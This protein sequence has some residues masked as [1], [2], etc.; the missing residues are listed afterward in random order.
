VTPCV[1]AVSLAHV[2]SIFRVEI[3]V[4]FSSFPV[5]VFE[6]DGALSRQFDLE[7]VCIS[8]TSQLSQLGRPQEEP[9]MR[10][11]EGTYNRTLHEDCECKGYRGSTVVKV[12]RYKSEGRWFDPR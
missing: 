11:L 4:S 6:L 5:F 8:D 7:T 9:N 2:A 3:S 10:L 1:L 12:L